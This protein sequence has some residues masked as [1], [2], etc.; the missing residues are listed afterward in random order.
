MNE[1]INTGHREAKQMYLH[2]S[3][4][5]H[6]VVDVKGVITAR[7][8]GVTQFC[9]LFKHAQHQVTENMT[10][11]PTKLN[12]L[13]PQEFYHSL[14]VFLEDGRWAERL[15]QISQYGYYNEYG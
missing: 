9:E 14:K 1:A 4:N 6:R 15:K 12:L 13:K 2:Y 10:F 3:L 7:L 11:D 8:E 5:T